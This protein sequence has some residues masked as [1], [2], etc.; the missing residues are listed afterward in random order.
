VPPTTP[1]TAYGYIRVG[2]PLAGIKGVH[3]VG[4]FV[5]KPDAATAAIYLERGYLW[6]S[7]NFIVAAETLL[8]ALDSYMPAIAT[9]A[10]AASN[11]AAELGPGV[12]QLGEAFRTAPRISID[13]AVMERTDRAAVAPVAFAWSD[14]GTWDA[15]WATSPKDADG[16]A[17]LGVTHL[18]DTRR[19]LVRAAEGMTVTAIGVANLAIVVEPGAVLVCDLGSAQG[20]K[21]AAAAMAELRTPSAGPSLQLMAQTYARWLSHNALP[22]WWA[23][24]ADHAHGGFHEALSI[25]GVAGDGPRR[26]RVLSRQAHVYA[27]A[28][29][30]ALPGPWRAAAEHAW[31][32]L[33]AYKRP[34]GLYRALADADTAYLDDQAALALALASLHAQNPRGGYIGEA[35]TLRAAIRAN[36]SHTQG[37]REAGERPYRSTPLLHLL[38]AAL[39]W[40]E[41][42]GGE[43]WRALAA[44][45][46]D[47]A[48]DRLIDADAGFIREVYDTDWRPTPGPD[49]RLVEPGHQFAWAWALDRWA[50]QS[51][52]PRA[53]TAARRLFLAG[54]KGFDPARDAVVDALDDSLAPLRTSARLWPQAERLKAAAR[55]ALTAAPDERAPWIAEAHSAARGLW[56]YLDVEPRGLW[57]DGQDANGDFTR[58]PALASSLYHLFEAIQALQALAP[59]L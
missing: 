33:D 15:I 41:A 8:T 49:G 21:A 13:Y 19:S 55:F 26:S 50:E 9:A 11:E 36:F 52:D 4:A 38:E 42:G 46:A 5:E 32:A 24:G 17:S 48:L 16:N 57:R 14:L 27:S 43:A 25:E 53:A 45:I 7:G 54:A 20:V 39:A 22:L 31:A 51:G 12:F 44:E 30:T 47:L 35:D 18:A 3:A 10:R 56:R 58:E 1:T 29:A 34:D 59:I 37:F 40:V 6:N 23:L 28:A 2:D